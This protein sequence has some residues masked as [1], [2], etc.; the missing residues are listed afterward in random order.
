VAD[1]VEGA[2]ASLVGERALAN[3]ERVSIDLQEKV[4]QFV[5][6]EDALRERFR[7]AMA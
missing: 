2:K 7:D 1:G 3:I 5:E 6:R 4:D